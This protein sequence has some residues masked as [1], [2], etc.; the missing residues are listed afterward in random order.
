MEM[1]GGIEKMETK[2]RYSPRTGWSRRRRLTTAGAV[3]AAALLAL[4][5]AS[6]DFGRRT[7]SRAAQVVGLEFTSGEREL[8][9]EGVRE[10]VE[11]YRAVREFRVDNGVAPALLFYPVPPG[12]EGAA[13][14]GEPRFSR[15]EPFEVPE[16]L[17]ELAFE[18]VTRLAALIRERKITSTELTKMYLARLKRLGPK[19][20]CVVTL[21]EERALKEAARADREIAQ[22]H[23]RGPLHGIPYGAKDLLAAEG[24][25]TTW[26][27][28]PYKDQVIDL[29]ATVIRRLEAAGAVLVAKLT[30][31]ALAWGDVWFGGQT[32]NPWNLEQGS[33]GSSAG[34]A[35]ATAAGLVPFALGS[36]TWGSIVSPATRCG[37]TGLRPT[38]GR[39]SRHGAMALSWSMDKLGPLCR[40]VEDCALVFDAIRGPDGMDRTVVDEPFAFDPAR[41]VTTL[42]V[43]YTRS[44]F[45]EPIEDEDEEQLARRREWRDFD[46][47]AL[48]V[49]RGLGVDLVPVELPGDLPVEALSF[50]LSA[51]A[52]A[53]FNDLT[54]SGLDDTL[55][56]QVRYA[57]PNQFREARLIPAVEYIQANRIRSLLIQ[58]M[59]EMME[60][61][62]V[63]VSPSYGGNNLLLTNLTGHPSVVLPHGFRTDGTPVSITFTGRLYGEA[64]ALAV[65]KA[66]QD[67][68]D[69]HRK[70]PELE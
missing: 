68:T 9:L 3:A 32:K 37:T 19:L 45:E 34:S 15:V 56:R 1:S 11:D 31:G 25:P 67:A 50:I 30:L 43:G 10:R 51:E 63:Y 20:E 27:A 47:A 69:H 33:S 49:L 66:F 42:R 48:D 2:G 28:T 46:L 41:D 29:D 8:M 22:G 44:L 54:L 40:E 18:P 17:E 4:G 70:H 13:T 21:T 39:V 7:L 60:T 62:D 52:A 5:A 57:W 64:E 55:V 61:V 6:P 24:Y 38:F 26:G 65:A 36:E 16:D 23:Y 59:E 14:G 12:G 58:R 53:A 35:A